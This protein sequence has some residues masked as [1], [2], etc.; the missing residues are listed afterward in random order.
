MTQ[1]KYKSQNE[2]L[3]SEKELKLIKEKVKEPNS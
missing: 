1:D 3:E 2:A